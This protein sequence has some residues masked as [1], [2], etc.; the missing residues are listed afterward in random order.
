MTKTILI[1][2]MGQGLSL[3]IAE[4]FGQEG[5][6]IGMISRSADKLLAFQ[7]SLQA[8]NI[9]SAF[10]TADVADT[11]QMLKAIRQLRESLGSIAVLQYNAVD[12]RM[13]HLSP[14]MSKN[15]PMAL[16]SA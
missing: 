10:A 9:S 14:K 15:S 1:I 2:G 5:Y 6:Q 12:Y 7:Q 16:K 4:K 11:A 13:K 3:G 8:Q